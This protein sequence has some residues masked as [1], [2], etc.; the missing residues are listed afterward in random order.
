MFLDLIKKIKEKILVFFNKKKTIKNEWTKWHSF[1]KYI[2]VALG[3]EDLVVVADGKVRLVPSTKS[4]MFKDGSLANFCLLGCGREHSSPVIASFC[5]F[6]E[7]DIGKDI[8]MW[9]KEQAE[10]LVKIVLLR[11]SSQ[12]YGSGEFIFGK[13][14]TSFALD[15]FLPEIRSEEELAM[16]TTLTLGKVEDGEAR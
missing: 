2:A 7:D 1:C 14:R 15:Q 12:E 6:N 8:S 10:S 16:M 13:F 4:S 5:F 11:G 9:S 3:K